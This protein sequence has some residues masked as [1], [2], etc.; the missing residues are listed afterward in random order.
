MKDKILVVG[1]G[2]DYE[3]LVKAL[4]TVTSD[5]SDFIKNTNDFKLVLFTGGE[6]VCPSFYNHS[7]PKNMCHYNIGRDLF[8][9]DIYNAAQEYDISM[10]GIC[11]GSQ[12]LNV[13]C[14]GWLMH[15]ISGHGSSHEM[16]TL[17][18]ETFMV[19][20]THHQMC[21]PSAEGHVIGFSTVNRSNTYIGDNDAE[22]DY[23][24]KEVEAI[25]YPEKHVFAVQF[26]P[27]Y[28]NATSAAR[29]WY[30]DGV[31]DLL[32]LSK[33]AFYTKYGL[34]TQTLSMSA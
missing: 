15:H 11:R 23:K 13:M 26:H 24:G 22:L 7:S 14:G 6:D 33:D 5:V 3:G 12:F 31:K 9:L 2:Y 8:E 16:T 32:E 1:G 19:T 18:G 17:L 21:M 29:K 30:V 27:E 20:S 34:G 25:Y 10:T 28:M 4:G